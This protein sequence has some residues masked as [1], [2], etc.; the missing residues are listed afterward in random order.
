VFTEVV[1]LYLA[2]G[3]TAVEG[4]AEEHEV[5]RVEWRP[6]PE[7]LAAAQGGDIRDAKTVV[8]IFRA[9]AFLPMGPT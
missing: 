5:F 4:V 7:L 3:L 2:T 6:L 1:H 8:G 9:A